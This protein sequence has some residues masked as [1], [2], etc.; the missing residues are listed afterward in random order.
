REQLLVKGFTCHASIN[1]QGKLVPF[2]DNIREAIEGIWKQK[3]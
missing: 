2:P 3:S 1:R